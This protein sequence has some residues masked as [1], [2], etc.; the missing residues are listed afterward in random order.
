MSIL[1]FFTREYE[2]RGNVVAML[3]LTGRE[4]LDPVLSKTLSRVISKRLDIPMDG[5]QWIKNMLAKKPKSWMPLK[6]TADLERAIRSIKDLDK[7]NQVARELE[8]CADGLRNNAMPVDEIRARIVAAS[9]G[10]LGM[11]VL[12]GDSLPHPLTKSKIACGYPLESFNEVLGG[13]H[14]NELV[15]LGGRPSMG[16]SAFVYNTALNC[17]LN[18]VGVLLFSPEITGPE[19]V[20]KLACIYKQINS[21]GIQR[22]NMTDEEK[23]DM[24]AAVEELREMP[25]WMVDK[26]G[27]SINELMSAAERMCLEHKEI[28]AIMVDYI[29][30]VT[31]DAYDPRHSMMRITEGL[32]HLKKSVDACVFVASQLNRAADE[33]WANPTLSSLKESG[34]I[35]E[36]GDV[37]M[38][39]TRPYRHDPTAYTRSQSLFHIL[40]NR[41]GPAGDKI[42]AVFD[43]TTGT[44]KDLGPEAQAVKE[45][46]Q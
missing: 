36:Q 25:L 8:L 27:I 11:E 31:T 15:F 17:L 22:D 35:E 5:I 42:E 39:V 19:A 23:A 16:K 2:T 34:T 40:K 43:E 12:H 1:D 10:E 44:F 20:T 6:T 29:Q 24:Q 13:L 4:T 32:L 7:K 38:I 37:V 18:G 28:G 33:F 46:F 3:E 45:V 9:S 41:H 14:K 30:I 26:T 21:T